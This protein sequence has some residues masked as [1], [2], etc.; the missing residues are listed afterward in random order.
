MAAPR[1]DL[2]I[3]RGVELPPLVFNMT[4]QQARNVYRR[5]FRAEEPVWMEVVEGKGRPVS[6]ILVATITR[7]VLAPAGAPEEPEFDA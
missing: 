3:C 5:F 4:S 2:T 7:V 1:S 6:L